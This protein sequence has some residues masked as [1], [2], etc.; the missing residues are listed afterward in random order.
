MWNNTDIP[1][2]FLITFR[3]HGTWLHGGVRGSV[4]RFRNQYKSPRLPHEKKWLVT[5]TS[6]LQDEPVILDG[7]QRV[8]VEEAA[9]ETCDFRKWHLHA[10]NVRTNHVHLVVAIGDKKPALA[11]NAFKANATRMMNKT[12]CWNR[13]YSPWADKGSCRYL[14]NEKSLARAIDYVLYG[15]GDDLLDFDD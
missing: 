12:G 7:D 8:C 13:T 11:L 1:L 4:S 15:Q 5:N 14:W 10:I 3:S 9:R 2:A 6:R